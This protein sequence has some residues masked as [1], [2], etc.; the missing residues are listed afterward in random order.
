[1]SIVNHGF[2]DWLSQKRVT[3]NKVNVDI[4]IWTQVMASIK[5]KELNRKKNLP[6]PDNYSMLWEPCP[7]KSSCFLS[8]LKMLSELFRPQLDS[9]IMVISHYCMMQ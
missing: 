7:D 1:M 3:A 4:V 9:R 6:Q 8:K 5:L 2:L